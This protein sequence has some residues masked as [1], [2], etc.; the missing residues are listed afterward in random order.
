M[1]SCCVADWIFCRYGPTCGRS[2][3]P[4][5]RRD[6]GQ[7]MGIENTG[8]VPRDRNRISGVM[9]ALMELWVRERDSCTWRKERR[10]MI[11][12]FLIPY[13]SSKVSLFHCF[14]WSQLTDLNDS[15]RTCCKIHSVVTLG[16]LGVDLSIRALKWAFF[17]MLFCRWFS[18]YHPSP[19]IWMNHQL[20]DDSLPAA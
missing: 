13:R 6:E 2:S 14:N 3:V 20:L 12:I 15:S 11:N 4:G 5:S 1:Y 10:A 16:P 17:L 18:I 19:P 7:R 8:P 9:L